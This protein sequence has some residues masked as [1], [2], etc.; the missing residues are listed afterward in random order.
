[1]AKEKFKLSFHR[2]ILGCRDF[3]WFAEL[4][5]NKFWIFHFKIF[6]NNNFYNHQ[7]DFWMKIGLIFF[8]IHFSSLT[9]ILF[10]SLERQT[11]KIQSKSLKSSFLFFFNL[12]S[13][14]ILH[15]CSDG[16]ISILETY[17]GHWTLRPLLTSSLSGILSH[18]LFPIYPIVLQRYW[19]E[20]HSSI[21]EA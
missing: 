19:Y 14:I 18:Q 21:E 20:R 1:M 15:K 2:V 5:I 17:L 10:T 3:L 11:Y 7:I 13:K 12:L 9:Q 4:S 6:L 8:T 16:R